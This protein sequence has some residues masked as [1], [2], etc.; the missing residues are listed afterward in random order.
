MREQPTELSVVSDVGESLA[1]REPS[2]SHSSSSTI[3]TDSTASNNSIA[4][5]KQ[6]P[7]NGDVRRA[8]PTNATPR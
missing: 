3:M 8:T 4:T 2:S 6:K 5:V 7:A 1:S